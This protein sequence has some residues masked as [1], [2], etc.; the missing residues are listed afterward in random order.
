MKIAIVIPT[1]NER[2]NIGP[3]LDRL[4]GALGQLYA[5]ISFIVVDDNSPDGTSD[6]V[7]GLPAY[8]SGRVTLL[9]A[10]RQ[11]LGAA[12]VRGFRHALENILPDIVVQMDADFSHRPDDIPRMVEAI[13]AGADLVIGGRSM[14]GHGTL[15]HRS[16]R[17]RLLSA[18]A[19]GIVRHWLGLRGVEDCTNG[20]RAWRA[21]SLKRIDFAAIGITGYA[22]QVAALRCAIAAGLTVVE[23]P[24]SF[25]RRRSGRSKLR[26]FDLAEFMR[27]VVLNRAPSGSRP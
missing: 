3:L 27:W 22:F 12:L 14:A 8:F 4:A 2:D 7:A 9:N 25:P 23:I 13:R 26:W 1:F 20:L 18:C 16:W 11:G 10:P 6:V 19:A 15:D 21:E 24:V 17:R 5:D